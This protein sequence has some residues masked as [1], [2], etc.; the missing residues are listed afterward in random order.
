M[1]NLYLAHHGVK[2][3]KWGIRRYQNPDGTTKKPKK[4]LS[5]RQK[6]F[7]KFGAKLTASVLIAYGAYKFQNKAEPYV[8]KAIYK[9]QSAARSISD[10]GPKI[11]RKTVSTNTIDK[12]KRATQNAIK[13]IVKDSS[14]DQATR[15]RHDILTANRKSVDADILRKAGTALKNAPR[16]PYHR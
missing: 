11:V 5:A 6:N 10:S 15:V 16:G 14:I 4:K 9:S 8:R 12:G 2:G 1:E 13:N 7:I 3:M